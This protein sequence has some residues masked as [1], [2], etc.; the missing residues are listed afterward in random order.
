MTIVATRRRSAGARSEGRAPGV[1]PLT[2]ALPVHL[3][4]FLTMRELAH[5]LRYQG[6]RPDVA[7]RKFVERHGLK[8]L[9]RGRVL[10]VRRTD[11]EAALEGR[12]RTARA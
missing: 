9:W 8:R 6:R 5:E 1:D 11:V 10:L 12:Y 3:P 4:L 2:Q 7:A